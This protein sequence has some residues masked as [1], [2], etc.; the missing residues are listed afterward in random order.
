MPFGRSPKAAQTLTNRITQDTY[1]AIAA[2]RAEP[3]L[4]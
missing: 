4:A 2:K 1:R 3:V